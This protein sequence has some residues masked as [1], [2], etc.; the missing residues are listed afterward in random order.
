[1][2]RSLRRDRARLEL[3]RDEERIASGLAAPLRRS[4]DPTSFHVTVNFDAV[5]R[6]VVE[7][8]VVAYRRVVEIE[9]TPAAQPFLK[10][11]REYPQG[12]SNP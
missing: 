3:P 12:D 1:M 6:I 11:Q 2:E 8:V 10:R 7:R 4:A 9:W 5:V